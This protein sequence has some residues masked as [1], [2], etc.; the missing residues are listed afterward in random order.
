[1]HG[2]AWLTRPIPKALAHTG[3]W[4]QNQAQKVILDF[5]DRGSTILERA[6]CSGTFRR[7][8]RTSLCATLHGCSP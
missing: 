8:S 3:A 4:L 5:I 2:E 6:D 1:M 7:P